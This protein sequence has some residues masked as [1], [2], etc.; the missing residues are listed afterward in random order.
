MMPPGIIVF[1]WTP[2]QSSYFN[3]TKSQ[4]CDHMTSSAGPGPVF[5]DARVAVAMLKS[6]V[7]LSRP[8]AVGR[9]W[10]VLAVSDGRQAVLQPSSQAPLTPDAPTWTWSRRRRVDPPSCSRPPF[11]SQHAHADTCTLT[12]TP[13]LSLPRRLLRLSPPSP[14]AVPP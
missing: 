9:R 6:A 10:C 12:C 4:T 8:G 5:W 14:P 7:C 11:I 2:A 3:K 1:T 13:A